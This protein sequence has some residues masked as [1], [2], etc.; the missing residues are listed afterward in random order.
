MYSYVCK[1]FDYVTKSD[2]N[3]VV[4]K[5]WTIDFTRTCWN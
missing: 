3:L 5:D 2:L 1:S 4:Y